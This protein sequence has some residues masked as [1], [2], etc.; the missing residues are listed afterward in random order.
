M[1][2]WGI[3]DWRNAEA[4][5]DTGQ[6]S[7]DRWR[8]EFV[9]RR[10]D[11]RRAFDATAQE[12]Y[13]QDVIW[14]ECDEGEPLKPCER[15]FTS[16][17]ELALTLGYHGLP[18][19]RFG[20]QPDYTISCRNSDG[21]IWLVYKDAYR[22]PSLA[23]LTFKLDAPIEA[24]LE[25]ARKELLER[26]SA[27]SGRAIKRRRHPAKWLTYLQALDARADGQSW[28]SIA[29]SLLPAMLETRDASA[30]RRLFTQAEALCFNF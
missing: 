28:N 25:S 2:D 19:P 18:N 22:D 23:Q 29:Q 10:D 3:P 5:G 15:G 26:Q 17:C 20:D 6:W 21:S 4:Y 1:T 12:T 30:G 27:R 16:G 9:R 14:D 24:Q 8:W 11:V 13:Q 7:T